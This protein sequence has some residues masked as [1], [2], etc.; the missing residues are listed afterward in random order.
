MSLDAGLSLEDKP[1]VQAW[2]DRC[3]ARPATSKGLDVPEPN[4]MK[5][6]A[7]DPEAAKKAVEDAQKMMVSTAGKQ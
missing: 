6:M 1:N 2:L 4:K 5:K 3:S 7:D